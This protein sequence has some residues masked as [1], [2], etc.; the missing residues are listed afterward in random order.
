MKKFLSA[1]LLVIVLI[2]TSLLFANAYTITGDVDNDG[3]VKASDARLVLRA[4]VGLEILSEEQ[5]TVS[6]IN[7]DRK[8]TASDARSILRAS[9]GL[10]NL[11]ELHMHNYKTEKIVKPSTC[12]EKGTKNIYCDC[13]EYKTEDIPLIEHKKVIDKAIAA[14]CT[15][16]GKTEGCHCSVCNTILIPQNSIPSKGHTF[17]NWT[18]TKENTCTTDGSKNGHCTVCDKQTSEIIPASGHNYDTIVINKTCKNDSKL[19]HKCSV[20]ENTYESEISKISLAIRLTGTSSATMN[21]YGSF[22]KSYAVTVDGG[23]GTK[24]L[25]FEVFTSETSTTPVDTMDF[26]AT[27]TYSIS[28]RG[29]ENTIDNYI[30]QITVKDEA[31]NQNVYRFKLGDLSLLNEKELQPEHIE[32]E[33]KSKVIDC[34]NAVNYT[35][36]TLC[37]EIMEEQ[38][39]PGIG[40][41]WEINDNITDYNRY[42]FGN[43]KCK[44]CG[45]EKVLG[46]YKEEI[47]FAELILND[48]KTKILACSNLQEANCLVFPDGVNSI[49]DSHMFFLTGK[50]K[51]V[52]LPDEITFS[53]Q[54]ECL[55]LDNKIERL[56][57]PE[58]CTKL[59]IHSNTACNYLIFEEG[60]T[61]LPYFSDTKNIVIPSSILA[62][63]NDFNTNAKINTVF[64][65][66]TEEEWN[67]L[68]ETGVGVAPL[69]LAEKYFY[70]ETQP[71]EEGNYWHYANGLPV[72]W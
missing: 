13:G 19:I 12:T 41:Y 69:V 29:Y 49:S 38:A 8:I 68:I 58:K 16:P 52:V 18:I 31:N 46:Q 61:E 4:S 40:H 33:T 48:D 35:E 66:G 37:G 9:V 25:K 62:I 14:T 55:V 32:S 71:T 60:M 11:P 7:N 47:V 43:H 42:G 63:N 1:I 2:C 15:T 26:V 28:Y 5:K 53:D 30:L 27:S 56:Y 6:D 54:Y 67:N 36:C 64:Y 21:G 22:T 17:G 45:E 24:Q 72:A 23:Y 50:I 10:E 65:G 39:V 20:C 59:N 51:Y 3:T 70:S 57:I 44:N 34:L